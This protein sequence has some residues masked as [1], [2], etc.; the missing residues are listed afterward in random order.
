MI[1]F[2]SQRIRVWI[3]IL[4]GMFVVGIPQEKLDAQETKP[5]EKVVVQWSSKPTDE[6]VE[7]A[8]K[9]ID[10]KVVSPVVVLEALE[11]IRLEEVVKVQ[12]ALSSK[13]WR[14]NQDKEVPTPKTILVQRPNA[15]ADGNVVLGKPEPVLL[16]A[17][18]RGRGGTG[19]Q[20]A[21]EAPRAEAPKAEA[22]KAEAPK[23][24]QPQEQDRLQMRRTE[25]GGG[26]GGRGPAPRGPV[27]DGLPRREA[28]VPER[29]EIARPDQN[30]TQQE[31][32]DERVARRAAFFGQLRSGNRQMPGLPSA[33]ER[34]QTDRPPQRDRDMRSFEGFGRWE[35]REHEGEGSRFRWYEFRADGDGESDPKERRMRIRVLGDERHGEHDHDH[36]FHDNGHE[37]HDH[38]HEMHEHDHPHEMEFDIEVHGEHEM[39]HDHDM[40]H[41]DEEEFEHGFDLDEILE[42]KGIQKILGLMEENFKLLAELELREAKSDLRVEAVEKEFG[43]KA[44]LM[45]RRIHELEEALSE[46]TE[47]LEDSDEDKGRAHE[48]EARVDELA[49]QNE[50]LH[51]ELDHLRRRAAESRDHAD[52]SN[53]ELMELRSRL[54]QMEEETNHLKE[55]LRDTA[56][57][58]E[59]AQDGSA[60]LSNEKQRLAR[61]HEEIE[62]MMEKMKKERLQLLN[63]R[64]MLKEKAMKFLGEDMRE[65]NEDKLR[66]MQTVVEKLSNERDQAIK[67]VKR[68]SQ[69][70]GKSS[71]EIHDKL[72]TENA[73]LRKSLQVMELEL[74]QKS[75]MPSP[76]EIQ[77]LELE[78]GRSRRIASDLESKVKEILQQRAK[79][80]LEVKDLR[81]AYDRTKTQSAKQLQAAEAMIRDSQKKLA[82]SEQK[83]EVKKRKQQSEKKSEARKK[84]SPKKKPTE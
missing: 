20:R 59:E 82:V 38:D 58:L 15:K 39:H 42:S 26:V 28:K 8:E 18:Q 53:A 76:S 29:Q 69:A 36:G 54:R 80:E 83:M 4:T 61:A 23:A 37:L 1:A 67:D 55:R 5:N 64:S 32:D 19:Q 60:E 3:P 68:M 51:K 13:V 52:R 74:H 70:A 73:S 33:P 27:Y 81:A 50:T 30:K 72:A 63:E 6:K 16:P 56:R 79:Q 48:L 40:H 31:S 7:V 34:P 71:S 12:P 77:K 41:E 25:S 10:E 2:S 84:K 44:E 14:A 21:K 35:P 57:E 47:A 17:A 49:H 43:F 22:P 45:E 66:A 9:S 62:E 75:S 11:P 78:F 65:L 24:R 46:T